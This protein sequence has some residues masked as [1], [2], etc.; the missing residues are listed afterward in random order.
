MIADRVAV[1]NRGRIEQIGS[2]EDVYY[3]SETDFVAQFIG[4]ANVLDGEV[5]GAAGAGSHQGARRPASA[6]SSRASTSR[7][8]PAQAGAPVGA[9]GADRAHGDAEGRA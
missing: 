9:A 1:M 8:G 7:N 3:R 2:P 5:V 6:R 4:L